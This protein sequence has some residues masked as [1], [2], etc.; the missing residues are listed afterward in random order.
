MLQQDYGQRANRPTPDTLKV[1]LHSITLFG[2]SVDTA[3][4]RK[5]KRAIF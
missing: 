2:S 5:S 1:N 3:L 4:G